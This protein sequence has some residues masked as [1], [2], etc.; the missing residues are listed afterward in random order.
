MEAHKDID[1][2][3]HIYIGQCVQLAKG[4]TRAFDNIVGT[5]A[6]PRSTAAPSPATST[7]LDTRHS[8]WALGYR[9]GGEVHTYIMSLGLTLL[10]KPQRHAQEQADGTRDPSRPCPRA[11]NDW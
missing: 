4:W 3:D 7:K 5:E 2:V 1:L 11:L 9:R 6:R 8:I 10:G